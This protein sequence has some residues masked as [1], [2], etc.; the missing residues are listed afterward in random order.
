MRAPIVRVRHATPPPPSGCRWCG[1]PQDSHGSQWI[2]SV[3][4]HTWAEPTR[5]QRLQRM[6]A[7]R[8]AARA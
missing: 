8:S 7:R 1:D 4:M 3:G 5:E 2:A 6:R